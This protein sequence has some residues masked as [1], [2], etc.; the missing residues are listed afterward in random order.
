MKRL[1]GQE[2]AKM[3]THFSISVEPCGLKSQEMKEV[4]SESHMTETI[5]QR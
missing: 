3:L 1:A 4:S 5:L 2:T